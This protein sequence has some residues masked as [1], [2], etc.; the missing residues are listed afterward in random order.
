MAHSIKKVYKTCNSCGKKFHMGQDR[1]RYSHCV[2]CDTKV[3]E[4][5]QKK[6][7]EEGG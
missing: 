2:R 1:A 5:Q 6:K 3:M 4:E 7:K